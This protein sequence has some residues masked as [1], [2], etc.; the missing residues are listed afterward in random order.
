MPTML[1]E[2]HAPRKEFSI[3]IPQIFLSPTYMSFGHLISAWIP[4][5]ERKSVTESEAI[6]FSTNCSRADSLGREGALE[7]SQENFR[8]ML[9]SRFSPALLDH[10]LPLCPRPAVCSHADRTDKLSMSEMC[11]LA[12]SLVESMLSSHIMSCFFAMVRI[13]IIFAQ[14]FTK[15]TIISIHGQ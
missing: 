15:I 9:N 6:S 8:T 10:L 2:S 4:C 1:E 5:K 11:L 12:S 13:L 14:I 7:S 3:S